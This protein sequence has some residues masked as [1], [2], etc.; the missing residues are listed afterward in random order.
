VISISAPARVQAE[1]R[2][3]QAAAGKDA[4]GVEQDKPEVGARERHQT[5]AAQ[6]RQG[7]GRVAARR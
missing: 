1:E 3:T 6:E 7:G 4:G 5:E 2:E